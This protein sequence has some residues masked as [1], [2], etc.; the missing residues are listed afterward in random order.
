MA[1]D[2]ADIEGIIK[3]ANFS[4]LKG[5]LEN[6]VFD[7][8]AYPYPFNDDENKRELCKDVAALANN[9]GGFLIIGVNEIVEL[10]SP[11]KKVDGVTGIDKSKVDKQKYSAFI[12]NYIYPKLDVEFEYATLDNKDIFYIKI[13]PNLKGKPYLV[14]RKDGYF[15][16]YIRTDES[17]IT[18]NTKEIHERLVKGA[19]FEDHLI[20]INDKLD[21]LV[22]KAATSGQPPAQQ[23]QDYKK[24]L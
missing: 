8:K 21:F 6:A 1:L 4:K 17:G 7:V 13:P 12:N 11:H 2:Y 18:I 15:A 9:K 10:N 16:Y 14:D 24:L 20:G 22:K 19:Q 23:P 3:T 5:E